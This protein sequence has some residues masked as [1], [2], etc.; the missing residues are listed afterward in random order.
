MRKRDRDAKVDFSDLRAKIPLFWKLYSE[1]P[2]QHHKPGFILKAG[3]RGKIE[4]EARKKNQKK[5]RIEKKEK[6]LSIGECKRS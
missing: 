3:S 6:N 4:G 2:E 5:G 1:F